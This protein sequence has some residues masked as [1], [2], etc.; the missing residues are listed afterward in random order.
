VART[1]VTAVAKRLTIVALAGLLAGGCAYMRLERPPAP[2]LVRCGIIQVPFWYGLDASQ[3]VVYREANC[4]ERREAEGY[5][6]A[7]P[8]PYFFFISSGSL[9]TGSPSYTKMP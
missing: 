2:E 8:E 4:I 9:Y 5:T 3:D 6:A 1:E 7:L